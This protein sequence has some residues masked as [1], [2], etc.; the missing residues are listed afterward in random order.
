MSIKKFMIIDLSLMALI[1]I[2]LEALCAFAFGMFNTEAYVLTQVMTIAFIVMMRWGKFG[3][4]HAF[5]GGIVYCALY[6]GTFSNF[7]IYSIGNL[8]IALSLL[9]FLKFDKEKVR[10]SKILT[11]TYCVLGFIG[12][13]LMRSVIAYTLVG[14]SLIATVT[15][16][17]TTDSLSFIIS[18]VAI[19]IARKQKG[20]FED[21]KSY[22]IRLS[23][24]E[25]LSGK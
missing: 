23:E 1:L 24:E 6:G 18:V 15:S 17:F 19:L 13:S 7:L 21:Q 12:L 10:L 20:L 11:I 2:G 3:L 9:L 22:L 16:F 4:V 14:E 8:G 5:I 25:K